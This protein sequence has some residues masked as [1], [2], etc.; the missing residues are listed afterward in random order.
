M[1]KQ[2]TEQLNKRVKQLNKRL[3][4]C[5]A[6]QD[7]SNPYHSMEIAWLET[8]LRDNIQRLKTLNVRG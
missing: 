7:S 4:Y 6:N 1:P 8:E 3:D 5:Q 2:E